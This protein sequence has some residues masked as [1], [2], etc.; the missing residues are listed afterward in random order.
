MEKLTVEQAIV[1][2][3]YTGV[4]MVKW[5]VFRAAIVEKLWPGTDPSEPGDIILSSFAKNIRE[6]YKEDF[7]ALCPE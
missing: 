4:T 2:Q 6:A 3:A 1:I 7:L 5:D